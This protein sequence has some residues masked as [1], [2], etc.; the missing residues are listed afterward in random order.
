[1]ARVAASAVEDFGRVDAW[2][3]A[4]AV[5]MF[6]TFKQASLDDFRRVPDVNFIG[7]VHGA[8]P[9]IAHLEKSAGALICIGSPLSDRGIPPTVRRNTRSKDGSILFAS[10]AAGRICNPR[11]AR[12]AVFDQHPSV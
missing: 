8:K 9:A 11:H 6:G 3:H 10:T 12:Q 1:M 4:A 5:S 2:V 7:Q